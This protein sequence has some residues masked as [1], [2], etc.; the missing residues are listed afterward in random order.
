MPRVYHYP[1]H[2]VLRGGTFAGGAW[3]GSTWTFQ[4]FGQHTDAPTAPS[5][6]G[7]SVTPTAPTGPVG[8]PTPPAPGTAIVRTRGT[9]VQP[10]PPPFMVG[11]APP[12]FYTQ[13][14]SPGAAS[15]TWKLPGG[16]K[17]SDVPPEPSKVAAW[18]D[19]NVGQAPSLVPPSHT[20]HHY[21]TLYSTMLSGLRGYG[22]KIQARTP[23]GYQPPAWS[24]EAA[25]QARIARLE[26]LGR[27]LVGWSHV[28]ANAGATVPALAYHQGASKIAHELAM[29]MAMTKPGL[30]A[31]ETVA[32]GSTGVTTMTTGGVVSPWATA[33]KERIQATV[34]G[35]SGWG[36]TDLPDAERILLDW[37]SAAAADPVVA[38]AG[39]PSNVSEAV[40]RA[41]PI[42]PKPGANGGAVL[43]DQEYA[44]STTVTTQPPTTIP[45]D[46]YPGLS[47]NAKLGIGVAAGAVA[48]LTLFR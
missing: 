20:G 15:R 32:P 12:G 42:S 33:Y 18:V 10:P 1:H 40:M 28:A 19:R 47:R 13:P 7:G 23:A 38:D 25:K 48:L 8:G 34:T 29:T 17:S 31:P 14:M 5:V 24:F 21:A 37:D 44:A 16:V 3:R 26:H 43:D 30:T 35:M 11:W 4:G 41:E 22:T 27:F 9:G 45:S 46:T 39:L 36:Q 6:P 2:G